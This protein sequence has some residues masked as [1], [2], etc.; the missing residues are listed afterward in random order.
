MIIMMRFYPD[1]PADN[2]HYISI[3]APRGYISA[4]WH[5]S[6]LVPGQAGYRLIQAL[7]VSNPER[8][9]CS[10]SGSDSRLIM[11]RQYGMNV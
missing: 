8:T 9:A 4:D 11:F 5:T 1:M 2:P 10:G 7:S 6:A 3:E